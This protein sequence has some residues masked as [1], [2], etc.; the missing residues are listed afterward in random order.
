MLLVVFQPQ[1]L[2]ILLPPGGTPCML[3]QREQ[4]KN[5]SSLFIASAFYI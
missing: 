5:M 3:G 1:V 2:C 4:H